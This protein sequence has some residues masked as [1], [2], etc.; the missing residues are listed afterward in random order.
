[1]RRGL[2]LF[3]AM[4]CAL[5]GGRFARADSEV[6]GRLTL[7][8]KS[9]T[10]DY[11]VKRPGTA[12]VP[13]AI[14][15]F[16]CPEPLKSQRVGFAVAELL[17]SKLINAQEFALLER[18]DLDKILKEQA[19]Q[20]TG[21][22][23]ENTAVQL[24]KVVGAKLTISGNVDKLGNAYQVSARLSDV[25]T[26]EVLAVAVQ[27]LPA[28]LFEAEAG[29][30]LNLVPKEQ[31]I[32]LFVAFGYGAAGSGSSAG[33][34]TVNASPSI[35]ETAG[36]IGQHPESLGLGVRYLGFP[37]LLLEADYRPMAFNE[38]LK[39]S[40]TSPLVPSPPSDASKESDFTAS[41]IH[42]AVDWV[43]PLAPRLRLLAGV[44]AEILFFT[45]PENAGAGPHLGVTTGSGPG[46]V[47]TQLSTMA[48]FPG[49]SQGSGSQSVFR[50]EAETGVEWKIQARLGWSLLVMASPVPGTL[51]VHAYSASASPPEYKDQGR[52]ATF[53]LPRVAAT[54]A[55]ALYF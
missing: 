24:G 5:A 18:S 31:A 53:T 36:I 29:S 6:S 10:A 2:T 15:D 8:A 12:K 30:Y 54:T 1:M 42:L 22:V 49:G 37:W 46:S 52:L 32:G 55:L 9:L 45:S 43:H 20:Q 38:R 26:G 51:E 41:A 34:V 14:F 21:A 47:T 16:A 35:S 44:G 7:L 50:L 33:P 23:Y 11:T 25:A 40:L 48:L 3:I 27:E 4:W 13:L 28:E 19:L 17:K 39:T